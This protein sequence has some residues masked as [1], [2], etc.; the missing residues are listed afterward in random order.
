MVNDQ[1]PVNPTPFD[2]KRK[3]EVARLGPDEVPGPFNMCWHWKATQVLCILK[4]GHAGDHWYSKF[5]VTE[6][7]KER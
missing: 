3:D 4:P 6:N 1:E 2:Q 5:T 7:T